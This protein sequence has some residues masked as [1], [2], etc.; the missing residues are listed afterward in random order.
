MG[1]ECSYK[2]PQCSVIL[3]QVRLGALASG[4]GTKGRGRRRRQ[5]FRRGCSSLP[6]HGRA[7]MPQHPVVSLPARQALLHSSHMFAEA[8]HSFARH[9]VLVDNP[10]VD[11]D[12]MMQQKSKAVAG[13][14]K[15][16]EGLFKKNKARRRGHGEGRG[17]VGQRGVCLRSPGRVGA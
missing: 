15:G 4:A 7:L 8:K 6:T 9:G 13:L 2:Q 3:G 12:V 16:I 5:A 14:T 10:R 1:P 11:V 17:G